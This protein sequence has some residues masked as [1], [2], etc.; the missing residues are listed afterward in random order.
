[1]AAIWKRR[2]AKK[3]VWIVD[4]R[5]A[6]GVRHRF[7]APTREQAETL[8]AEKIKER[9]EP[10]QLAG[11][12]DRTLDDFAREWLARLPS[13]ELKPRTVKSYRQ[14]YKCHLAGPLGSIKLRDLRRRH[15]RALLTAKR[16]TGGLSKNTTRLVRACLST[17]LAD[18]VEDELIA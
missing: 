8:L 17:M 16:G 14:L 11:D 4:C 5:D 6:A 12:P 13:T 7:T 18:A 2:R 3:D 10:D 15:V 9:G 1:M